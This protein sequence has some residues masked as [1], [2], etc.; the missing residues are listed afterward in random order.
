M[1]RIDLINRVRCTPGSGVRNLSLSVP[2]G[3]R[4]V[5][6]RSPK[7]GKRAELPGQSWYDAN[8]ANHPKLS[9]TI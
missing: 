3:R 7:Q 9:A 5:P 8:H 2:M 1:P 6:F 4:I